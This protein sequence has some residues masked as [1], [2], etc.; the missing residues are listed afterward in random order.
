M[1]ENEG[2]AK[3][4]DESVPETALLLFREASRFQVRVDGEMLYAGLLL[5]V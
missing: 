1:A 2:L 5:P 4:I 3:L